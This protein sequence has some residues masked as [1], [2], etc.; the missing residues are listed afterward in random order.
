M[1]HFIFGVFFFLSLAV[2]G[3]K[4]DAPG[5]E[6]TGPD[7]PPPTTF[8]SRDS[9]FE[10]N[11]RGIA[12]NSSKDEVFSVLEEYRKKSIVVYVSPVNNYF[13]D[14]TDLKARIHLFD[15]VVLDEKI[16]TDSGVQ[17]QLVSGEVK[18]ITLNNRRELMQWPEA[19]TASESI[20]IGDQSEV[21]YNK[22]LALSIRSEYAH[23]FERIVLT[24]LYT[25]A[26]Y[27]PVLASMPWSFIYA[28]QPDLSEQIRVHFKE[29]KVQYITVDHFKKR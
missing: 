14:I 21:L 27:D 25:F 20:Q 8:I 12:I 28:T 29:K 19:S 2:A 4:F 17:L 5:P 24:T 15:Y 18:S 16:D 9:I 1:K 11:Y 23:K 6:I 13:F 26:L 10:G 22:L 7:P 3:C